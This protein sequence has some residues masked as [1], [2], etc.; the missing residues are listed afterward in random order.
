VQ[1]KSP[2]SAGTQ[3]E[4][5]IVVNEG[6]VGWADVIFVME[7]SHLQKL[8]RKLGEALEGKEIITLHIR[9]EFQ[10]MQPELIEELQTKVSQHI[11]LPEGL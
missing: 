10:F 9:D 6:H 7:K 5:R 4:A 11:N 8:R 2:A 1:P 3:P